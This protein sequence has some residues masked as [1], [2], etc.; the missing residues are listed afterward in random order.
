MTEPFDAARDHLAEHYPT[1]DTL[2]IIQRGEIMLAYERTPGALDA[3][4]NLKS[5]TK[6]VLSALIGIA[7]AAGDIP[8]LDDTIGKLM[9][10]WF[11][12][13]TDPRL[14]SIRVRDLLMLRS[15]LD[16]TEFHGPSTVQ[17]TASP[18]WVRFVLERPLIHDPGTRHTYSTGD[19]H[20]LAALLQQRTG[21]SALD[22]ATYYLFQPLGITGA[23][24]ATD[25]QGIHVGGSELVLT[26]RDMAKFGQLYLNNGLRSGEQVIPADW[27]RLSTQPH[28]LVIPPGARG[29]TTISYGY[30]W[31]LR[32]QGSYE[33]FMA[34]GFG[35]QFIVVIP[36][37]DLVVVLTG[38]IRNPP[39]PFN[40]NDMLCQ[41][42]LVQDFIVPYA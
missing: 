13:S 31:W 16:W 23:N 36:A 8:S 6:S 10:G 33:S 32:P 42:N 30:L 18:D 40:D 11:T 25:P 39:E 15:G 22:F 26:P 41:F 4:H 29:C 28:T 38:D 35:G 19:T 12:P 9:P 3:P 17:M 27:V 14:R 1:L 20:L 7:L 37:L 34:V 21:M 24:W 5:A 2:L